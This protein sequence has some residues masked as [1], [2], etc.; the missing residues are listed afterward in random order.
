MVF[1]Y[2]HVI[3]RFYELALFSISFTASLVLCQKNQPKKTNIPNKI[4]SPVNVKKKMGFEIYAFNILTTSAPL[5]F[6]T[7]SIAC[8][9]NKA[10]TQIK[11]AA[12]VYED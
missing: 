5:Y 10:M 12:A 11:K 7:V 3:S 9:F 6:Y 8:E 2:P 1:I 4:P